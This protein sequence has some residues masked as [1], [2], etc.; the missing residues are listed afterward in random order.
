MEI[1]GDPTHVFRVPNLTPDPRTGHIASWTEEQFLA[2][3]RVGMAY[4]GSHMPWDAYKRMS[5][6]DLRAMYRYLM[7]LEPVENETGPMLQTKRR[8]GS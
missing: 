5:D 8:Q 2:R 6:D 1:D 3:F 7:S 4:Q